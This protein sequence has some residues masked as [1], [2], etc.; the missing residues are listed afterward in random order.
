[1]EMINNEV[2][3]VVK[4]KQLHHMRSD[5]DEVVF[6]HNLDTSMEPEDMHAHVSTHAERSR[7]TG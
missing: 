1:M 2:K 4:L 6:G 5:V 7:I 3:D